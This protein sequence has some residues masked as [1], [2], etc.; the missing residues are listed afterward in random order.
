LLVLHGD[1]V[2]KHAAYSARGHAEK[3]HS[4]VMHSHTHRMGSSLERIPAVGTRAEAVRR[5]Y[6][7]GCLCNLQPSYVSAPNWTNG[8]AI[9]SHDAEEQDYG[10]ELVNIQ[11]GQAVVCTAGMTIR[12]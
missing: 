8:F 9:I 4:S 1:L 6:E 2:R 3:W 10:V 5:A 7:I 12:A 11:R